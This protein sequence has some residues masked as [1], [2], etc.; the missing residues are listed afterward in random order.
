MLGNPAPP[1][2]DEFQA[3][4]QRSIALAQITHERI[5]EKNSH[6]QFISPPQIRAIGQE[7]EETKVLIIFDRC[8]MDSK[9]F[10]TNVFNSVLKELF[11]KIDE[12]TFREENLPQFDMVLH[13]ESLACVGVYKHRSEDTGTTRIH[14]AQEAW[15]LDRKFTEIFGKHPRYNFIPA[16]NDKE[17]RYSM[18]LSIIDK[19]LYRY[20]QE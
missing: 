12:K 15:E 4:F 18:L 5:A 13:M 17:V 2:T 8:L 19:L 1:F 20:N 14:T 3:M 11:C 10:Q 7:Y 6:V 9:V 16:C